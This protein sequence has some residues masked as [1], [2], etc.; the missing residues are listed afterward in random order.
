MK[1]VA[2]GTLIKKKLTTGASPV[3]VMPFKIPLWAKIII[4][5]G[6]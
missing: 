3:C 4:Y 6:F 5:P 1:K 2:L